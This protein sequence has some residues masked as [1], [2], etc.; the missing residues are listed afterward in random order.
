M[1]SS[2]PPRT[3]FRSTTDYGLVRERGDVVAEAREVA[4]RARDQALRA[5][6]GHPAVRRQPAPAPGAG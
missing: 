4:E 5:P 3:A 6:A 2:P 1:T